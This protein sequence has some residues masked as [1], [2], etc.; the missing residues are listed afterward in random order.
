M[1]NQIDMG[2]SPL[3]RK[4]SFFLARAAR[5]DTSQGET[6]CPLELGDKEN[7]GRGFW[8]QLA[9]DHP[10]GEGMAKFFSGLKVLGQ[11][12]FGQ[13]FIGFS[14]GFEWESLGPDVVVDVGGGPGDIALSIAKSYPDREFVVQ[15]LEPGKGPVTEKIKQHGLQ[16]RVK[17]QTQD[18]FQMQPSDLKPSAYLLVRIFHDWNDEDCLRIIRPLLPAMKRYGTKILVAERI[19]SDNNEQV[20]AYKEW[21]GRLSDISMFLFFGA[22]ERSRKEWEKLLKKADEGL[23]IETFKRP[24]ST[25]CAFMQVGLSV[26]ED[27]FVGGSN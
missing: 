21:S 26:A 4:G 8:K 1:T 13:D 7:G 2:T 24:A 15:D 3:V 9:E 25:A 20:P 22:K 11:R 27:D 6:S 12:D 17:F 19:L 16:D 10:K 14:Q 23:S 5:H 18:F